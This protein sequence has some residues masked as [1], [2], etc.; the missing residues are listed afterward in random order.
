MLESVEAHLSYVTPP[1]SKLFAYEF[2][3]PPGTQRRSTEFRQYRVRI[4]NA[5]QL[6][7]Q[8][9]LDAQGFALRRQP[10]RVTDFYDTAEVKAVYY[11]ELE[12]LVR[13]ATGASSILI[14]DHTVRGDA[15]SNRNG[16]TIQEPV[17]RVHNDYTPESGSRR[18]LDLL[19]QKVATW[20]LQHRVLEVN[21][22]RPIRGPLRTRPL[23]VCDATS[24]QPD[25]FVACDLHY[26][27]RVGEIYYVQYRERHRWYYFPD[28]RTDEALLLKCFDS[29]RAHGS[30]GAHA[31]FEHPHT[32]PDSLPRE[33][34]EARAFAFF[35]PP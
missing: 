17:H 27:D 24:M 12:R 3:P 29:N 21:V 19:P 14:F 5:R 28:M 2:D 26:R 18:V 33:S 6:V 35:A 25:D 1:A 20:L 9:T 7:M 4:H 32:P 30:A 22:W 16:T 10:T 8:P 15:V 31:A 13:D 23:A 11:G 34:I